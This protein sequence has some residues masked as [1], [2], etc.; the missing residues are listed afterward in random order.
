MDTDDADS[1]VTRSGSRP[2]LKR[3]LTSSTY[4]RVYILGAIWVWQLAMLFVKILYIGTSWGQGIWPSISALQKF[5]NLLPLMTLLTTL[6]LEI[7][8]NWLLGLR[9]RSFLLL[10]VIIWNI[11][12]ALAWSALIVINRMQNPQAVLHPNTWSVLYATFL[13]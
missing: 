4:F 1:I 2:S 5:I 12:K 10:T 8:V 3:R 7:A 11:V 6:V 13:L 9:G